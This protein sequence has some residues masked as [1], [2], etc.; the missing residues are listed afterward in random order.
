MADA[1]GSPIVTPG[2]PTE[3]PA[4]PATPALAPTDT[5]APTPR[6]PQPP[7]RLPEEFYTVTGFLLLLASG[8]LSGLIGSLLSYLFVELAW[9]QQL[10][11]QQKRRIAALTSIGLPIVAQ[12]LLLWVPGDV[13]GAI[14]PLWAALINGI[15][16]LYGNKATYRN[17]VKPQ[18][19]RW[20][21]LGLPESAD[22]GP[23]RERRRITWTC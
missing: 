19:R 3:T 20:E 18:E 21:I 1:G 6:A 2:A 16:R 5:P 9:F 4:P 15:A 12:A 11:S 14:D 7:P 10:S 8:S 13:W 17:K 22:R 23:A